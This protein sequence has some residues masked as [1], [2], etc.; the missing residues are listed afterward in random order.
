L[1]STQTPSAADLLEKVDNMTLKVREKDMSLKA[2]EEK[3]AKLEEN[4]KSKE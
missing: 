4:L 3:R 2:A 1:D